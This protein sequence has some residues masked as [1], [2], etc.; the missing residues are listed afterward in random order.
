MNAT[1]RRLGSIWRFFRVAVVSDGPDRDSFKYSAFKYSVTTMP[2]ATQ[3]SVI[4]VTG[5]PGGNSDIT[6]DD[7]SPGHCHLTGKSSHNES[8]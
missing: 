6:D 2:A 8:P 5:R 4:R 3:A 7:P 1:A